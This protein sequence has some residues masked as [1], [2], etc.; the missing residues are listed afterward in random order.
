MEWLLLAWEVAAVI[1]KRPS[2]ITVLA[3][4]HLTWPAG[5][6]CLEP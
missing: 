4:L 6:A 3:Y 2:E 5:N 1:V